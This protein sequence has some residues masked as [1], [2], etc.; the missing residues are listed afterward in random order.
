MPGFDQPLAQWR[1]QSQPFRAGIASGTNTIGGGSQ[2]WPLLTGRDFR[3]IYFGT[4]C[5]LTKILWNLVYSI[6]LW[7]RIWLARPLHA[8]A[9]GSS[10]RG[11]K[12]SYVTG[13][14]TGARSEA[15]TYQQRWTETDHHGIEH[16][17]YSYRTDVRDHVQLRVPDGSIRAV[18][19]LNF[20]LNVA[21]ENILTMC[22]AHKSMRKQVNIVAINPHHQ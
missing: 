12:L 21:P 10:L 11:W 4:W 16:S 9:D 1:E 13:I 2:H 6:P 15:T 18:S 5:R 14:V 20:H 19:L 8:S 22:T 17:T 3:N 7:R